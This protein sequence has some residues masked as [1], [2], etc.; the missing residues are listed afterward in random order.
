MDHHQQH[1][2]SESVDHHE[3][4]NGHPVGEVGFH[5]QCVGVLGGDGWHH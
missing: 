2:K 1:A 3:H 5:M 4:S